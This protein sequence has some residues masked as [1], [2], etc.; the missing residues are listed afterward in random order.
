MRSHRLSTTARNQ[1]RVSEID[2]ERFYLAA[3]RTCAL[4]TSGSPTNGAVGLLFHLNIP[5]IPVRIGI[6][7]LALAFLKKFREKGEWTEAFYP[8]SDSKGRKAMVRWARLVV[9]F[10]LILVAVSVVFGLWPLL[11]II[12]LGSFIANWWRYFVVFAQ[13]S[14]WTRAHSRLLPRTLLHR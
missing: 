2:L 14:R 13:L 5:A 1:S 10:H 8:D 11:I 7:I 3:T 12:T 4:D 6:N 9:L